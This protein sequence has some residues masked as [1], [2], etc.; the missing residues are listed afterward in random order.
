MCFEE[1]RIPGGIAG[2]ME[3]FR[4]RRSLGYIKSKIGMAD[5]RCLHEMDEIFQRPQSSLGHMIKLTQVHRRFLRA[6]DEYNS[7]SWLAAELRSAA[8]DVGAS[9]SSADHIDGI[10]VR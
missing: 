6:L 10:W 9:G 1:R 4:P 5:A 7:S 3:T 2:T 8:H